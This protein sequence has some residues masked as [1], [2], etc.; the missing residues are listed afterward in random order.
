VARKKRPSMDIMA[1]LGELALASRLKRMSEALMKDAAGFYD[2][3]GVSFQPRWFTVF[4]TLGRRSPLAVGELAQGL[5]LTHPAVSQVADQLVRAGLARQRKDRRDDRR[6]LLSLTPAGKRLH[7]RLVPVWT[8]VRAAA[9]ELL[10]EAGTDLLVNMEHVEAALA[11]RSVMDRVRGRLG[12]AATGTL[13]IAEYR[14]A[15]KKHF[16]TLNEEWLRT[17]FEIEEHD[18]RILNDPNGT[19]IRKGGAILFALL[20]AEVVGTAAL[21]RHPDDMLELCKMAVAPHVRRRGIGTALVQAIITHARDRGAPALYLQTSPR[22]ADAVR[23]YRRLG[24]RALK[25]NPLPRPEYARCSITMALDLQAD[26]GPAK[27][28]SLEVSE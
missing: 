3:L 1:E 6:R 14:P 15:Y 17:T 9:R 16:K 7:R 19:V 10:D 12:M 28:R 20:D 27:R 24:F 25:R 26:P 2:D 21:V 13:R 4:F 18:A 5:G 11:Q 23:L 22:L 8:E